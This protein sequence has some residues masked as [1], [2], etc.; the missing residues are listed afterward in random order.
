[1]FGKAS[2]YS[3]KTVKENISRCVTLK[4]PV[5]YSI[6]RQYLMFSNQGFRPQLSQQRNRRFVMAII[7]TILVSGCSSTSPNKTSEPQADTYMHV[8][9]KSQPRKTIT[10]FTTA[11]QCL[12]GLLYENKTP[13]ILVSLV[14]AQD[15]DGAV[16]GMEDM[17]MTSLS[18][19]SVKSNV[20]K[21]VANSPDMDPFY[22]HSNT[23]NFK[24][25]DVFI[26]ISA[27]QFENQVQ[28]S[29]NSGSLQLPLLPLD[30]ELGTNRKTSIVSIDMNMG[31]GDTLQLLPGIFSRNSIT[32]LTGRLNSTVSLGDPTG[33]S[34]TGYQDDYYY[35]DSDPEFTDEFAKHM[36]SDFSVG[37]ITKFG[38]NFRMN[39]NYREGKHAAVRTLVELGAIELIGKYA[40]LPYH[41]CFTEP[42][43]NVES[44]SQVPSGGNAKLNITNKHHAKDV[45]L[46]NSEPYLPLVLTL[47]PVGLGNP[48]IY[49]RGDEI[50]LALN[51]SSDAYV[52]CYLQQYN[53]DIFQIFPTPYHQTNLVFANQT[54]SLPGDNR[55]KITVDSPEEKIQCAAHASNKLVPSK[56]TER[57]FNKLNYSSLTEL[58]EQHGLENSE[59]SKSETLV[60]TPNS[61]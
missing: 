60:I 40:N 49:N 61:L 4:L 47:A 39:F 27:P 42:S 41:Q 17:L 14:P 10:N 11:L 18:E 7:A 20:I 26:R 55:L 30:G 2:E 34:S 29:N 13:E 37:R 19:M 24:A 59:F 23:Q 46:P 43:A 9:P 53:G 31:R 5:T 48:V 35:D 16:S 36:G 32:I 25:P 52:Y 28:G 57:T 3:N 21:V 12:D 8:L 33:D 6:S 51:V 38:V 15:G 22:I 56:L 54:I 58:L 44:T 45:E 1:M 50:Q